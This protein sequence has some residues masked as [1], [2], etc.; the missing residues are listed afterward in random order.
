MFKLENE[1]RAAFESLRCS[2]PESKDDVRKI[3]AGRKLSNIRKHRAQLLRLQ[4]HALSLM[5]RVDYA[6]FFPTLRP[7]AP[8][9]TALWIYFRRMI[10]SAPFAVRP[11]RRLLYWV[12]DDRSGGVLGILELCSE[13]LVLKLR[14]DRIGWT[15]GRML[16][17]GLNH[18][19][20]IGTC[21]CVHPFGIL[22]GGKFIMTAATGDGVSGDWTY[23]Y[24]DRLAA[25]T[26]TSLYG[27][28]SVYNRI[29]YWEYLGH[30]NSTGHFQID[31]RTWLT[32]KRFM[33]ANGLMTRKNTSSINPTSRTDSQNLVCSKLKIDLS[34]YVA[35]QPRGIYFH[36][37]GE[38]A[39]AYLRGEKPEFTPRDMTNDRAARWWLDR[40]YS[41]RWPKKNDEIAAFD[42]NRYKVDRK[43]EELVPEA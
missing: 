22:T 25:L 42:W 11:G 9:D 27:R 35:P 12:V 7:V 41:M 20:S 40:W 18:V 30:T 8:K 1:V 31:D 13:L 26:T 37:R 36:A 5:K 24:G 23:K 15:R 43:I 16:G 34:K 10:S 38:D 3:M 32:I 6:D 33:R 28:S 17:G 21:V 29:K 14:D 39:C 19:G 4:P 2:K